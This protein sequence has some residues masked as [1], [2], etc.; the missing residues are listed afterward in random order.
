MD[1]GESSFDFKCL[2][3]GAMAC[4][5]GAWMGTGSIGDRIAK[6]EQEGCSECG[7]PML[8]YHEEMRFDWDE[9][10]EKSYRER[11]ERA[12]Q[13]CRRQMDTAIILMQFL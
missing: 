7:G 12:R 13:V 1:I 5:G 6:R 2:A 10:S 3:C 11:Y 9:Y 8:L 4:I